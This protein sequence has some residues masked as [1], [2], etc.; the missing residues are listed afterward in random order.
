MIVNKNG[1]GRFLKNGRQF[2][3]V[4]PPNSSRSLFFINKISTPASLNRLF[5]T[6]TKR[7]FHLPMLTELSLVFAIY[8]FQESQEKIRKSWYFMGQDRFL[9]YIKKDKLVSTK[10][11]LKYYLNKAKKSRGKSWLEPATAGVKY[12]AKFTEKHL[13]QSL[14]I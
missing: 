10:F 1:R 6:Y 8:K 4:L 9:L 3:S 14:F 12:C 11:C 7:S 2:S 5:C 13:C